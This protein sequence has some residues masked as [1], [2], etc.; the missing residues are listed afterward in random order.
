ME[1][2]QEFFLP[3]VAG[4][5]INEYKYSPC[6]MDTLNFCI[7]LLP[8]TLIHAKKCLQTPTTR[9]VCSMHG[10]LHLTAAGY[11]TIV[12][13]KRIKYIYIRNFKP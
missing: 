3:A 1:A 12:I 8:R 13:K 9:V 2:S 10:A 11:I 5:N 6:R 4:K 7:V